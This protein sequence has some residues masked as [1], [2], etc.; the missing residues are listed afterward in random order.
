M[1]NILEQILYIISKIFYLPVILVL[2]GFLVFICFQCGIFVADFYLR[3]RNK[4]AFTGK[5]LQKMAEC[6]D[7]DA[8][9]REIALAKIIHEAQDDNNRKIQSAKYCVKIGSTVGLI[10][11]LSPMATALAGLSAGNFASLSQQMVTAFSTTIIGL[12]VGAAAYS[13]AHVRIQWQ[14]RERFLLDAAA[15]D[16]LNLLKSAS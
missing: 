16:N 9:E 11:T 3:I 14:R 12:I 1:Q 2:L 4:N 10:G 13:I 5:A 8:D 6:S 15:E 7:T